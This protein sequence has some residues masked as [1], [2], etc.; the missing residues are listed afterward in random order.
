MEAMSEKQLRTDLTEN[1]HKKL[2]EFLEYKINFSKRVTDYEKAIQEWNK[3]MTAFVSKIT[4]NLYSKVEGL[5][6]SLNEVQGKFQDL[7][8]INRILEDKDNQPI[9]LMKEL[10]FKLS[11]ISYHVP[12]E[13]EHFPMSL[14]PEGEIESIRFEES[15]VSGKDPLLYILRIRFYS[16]EKKHLGVHVYDG[17]NDDNKGSCSECGQPVSVLLQLQMSQKKVTPCPTINEKH[18]VKFTMDE[19]NNNDI[20]LSPLGMDVKSGCPSSAGGSAK[21]IVSFQPKTIILE[22]NFIEEGYSTPK[23]REGVIRLDDDYDVNAEHD[24]SSSTRTSFAPSSPPLKEDNIIHSASKSFQRRL[25]RGEFSDD[26]KTAE[27]RE[28]PFSDV[29]KSNCLFGLNKVLLT[30]TYDVKS[31]VMYPEMN[32][33]KPLFTLLKKIQPED[34]VSIVTLDIM[35][36]TILKRVLINGTNGSEICCRFLSVASEVA[37]VSDKGSGKMFKVDLSKNISSE[38]E[39]PSFVKSITCTTGVEFHSLLNLFIVATTNGT[40]EIMDSEGAWIKTMPFPG[41]KVAGIYLDGDD[42]YSAEM[43]NMVKK[44]ALL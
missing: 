18:H 17:N 13:L 7:V 43:L 4:F 12:K 39:R 21:K 11:T 42:L 24:K 35:N 40:L 44:Y 32:L 3:T 6:Q 41:E 15:I 5:H 10:T 38:V 26:G 16:L 36:E 30:D 19:K 9:S 29:I 25:S 22:E 28:N 34:S 37:I 31:Q 27:E 33:N 2:S 20:Q 8:K 23:V 14:S 1:V